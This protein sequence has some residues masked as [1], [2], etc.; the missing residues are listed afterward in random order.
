MTGWIGTNADVVYNWQDSQ[1]GNAGANLAMG[2]Y[3][4]GLLRNIESIL[5]PHGIDSLL[6]GFT[7]TAE[8]S[9]TTP[10]RRHIAG[11]GCSFTDPMG[12]AT[13]TWQDGLGGVIRDSRGQWQMPPPS[14]AEAWRSFAASGVCL[15]F[16]LIEILLGMAP[17]AIGHDQSY[18]TL[19]DKPKPFSRYGLVATTIRNLMYV[20]QIAGVI[21]DDGRTT[22]GIAECLARL[23]PYVELMN[24]H[25]SRQVG[26]FEAYKRNRARVGLDVEPNKQEELE[27][28]CPWAGV[29]IPA[30]LEWHFG[31]SH[32]FSQQPTNPVPVRYWIEPS[33]RPSIHTGAW[34]E[35]DGNSSR[36]PTSKPEGQSGNSNSEIS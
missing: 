10:A 28:G 1:G 21:L 9:R 25:L 16:E 22:I 18:P 29:G 12:A 2:D 30:G 7:P 14:D 34:E 13:N 6:S 26:H 35:I 8:S 4:S 11:T 27:R 23:G 3:M 31:L 33:K 19:W 36:A 24:A 5:N 32:V 15:D 17:D 20:G